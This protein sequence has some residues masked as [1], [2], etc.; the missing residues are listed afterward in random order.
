ML[1]LKVGIVVEKE[2]DGTYYAYCPGIKGIHVPGN[3]EDEALKN[4]KEAISVHL[5]SIMKHND[6]L[7]VGI[8][9]YDKELSISDTV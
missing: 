4:A 2:D 8:V 5:D 7:P 1:R 9:D 3:T 6:P